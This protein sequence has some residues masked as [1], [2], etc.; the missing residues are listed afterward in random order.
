MLALRFAVGEY[1][2]IYHEG[3]AIGAIR[4]S[5]VKPSS[6]SPKVSV[7]FAGDRHGFEVLRPSVVE[8]RFGREELERLHRQFA[9]D[10][11]LQEA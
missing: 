5:E 9:L 1:A 11:C 4:L 2:F 6:A 8:R 10:G 7:A 3:T